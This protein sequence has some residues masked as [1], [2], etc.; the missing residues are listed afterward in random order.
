MDVNA[1]LFELHSELRRVDRAILA[2][3]ELAPFGIG[4][5]ASPLNLA[6]GSSR[7]A[8]QKESQHRLLDF[9]SEPLPHPS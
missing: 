1:I 8:Q 9:A 3:H 7:N 4:H 6:A 2:L 5:G